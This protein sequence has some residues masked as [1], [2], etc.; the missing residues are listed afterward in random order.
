MQT[1]SS[2][3]PNNGHEDAMPFMIESTSAVTPPDD[4]FIRF[5]EDLVA[6]N[7]AL[8]EREVVPSPSNA[9]GEMFVCAGDIAALDRQMISQALAEQAVVNAAEVIGDEHVAVDRPIVKPA[10]EGELFRVRFPSIGSGIIREILKAGKFDHVDGRINDASY[11][12][13][14]SAEETVVYYWVLPLAKLANGNHTVSITD[15]KKYAF[16]PN[17]YVFPDL[18]EGVAAIAD[19]YKRRG[20]DLI[21]GSDVYTAPLRDRGQRLYS[22]SGNNGRAERTIWLQ[23]EQQ[24]FAAKGWVIGVKKE[25]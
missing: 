14:P 8:A 18:L 4:E 23:N 25:V 12:A 9:N 21:P 17:E 22:T 24:R 2:S 16:G 3:Q 10:A 1:Q 15:I 11:P 6:H 19:Q 5:C 20:R 7:R 13:A